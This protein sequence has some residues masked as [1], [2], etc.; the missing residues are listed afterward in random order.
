[1]K[2]NPSAIPSAD[3]FKKIK[4]VLVNNNKVN[5]LFEYYEITRVPKKLDYYD[6]DHVITVREWESLW[7]HHK[8]YEPRQQTVSINLGDETEL[9][10]YIA[11]PQIL[12]DAL[13]L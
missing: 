11:C 3:R 13:S 12:Y 8:L 5:I 2:L 9:E 10:K 4:E 1:M 7:R 6:C